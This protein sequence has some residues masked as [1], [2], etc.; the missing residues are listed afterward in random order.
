MAINGKIDLESFIYYLMNKVKVFKNENEI[1]EMKELFEFIF[2]YFDEG[3]TLYYNF[4]YVN[5][6]NFFLNR[7]KWRA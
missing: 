4:K 1:E 5:K 2:K 7:W 3:K 6:F